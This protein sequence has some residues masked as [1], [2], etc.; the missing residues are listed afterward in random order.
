MIWCNDHH[1]RAGADAY[2]ATSLGA[3]SARWWL[4]IPTLAAAATAQ[5]ET[6]SKFPPGMCPKSA[7]SEPGRNEYP[8]MYDH[9]TMTVSL[10]T[11]AYT[12][13]GYLHKSH[14]RM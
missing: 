13:L 10:S 14:R 9:A 11:C 3:P 8:Q 7:R 2:L 1:G 5:I 12:A 4:P 6:R